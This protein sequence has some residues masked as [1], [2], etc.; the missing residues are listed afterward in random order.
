MYNGKPIIGL[1]AS[2]K[3]D[4]WTPRHFLNDSYCHAIRHFGGIPVLIPVRAQK[5][6][7]EYLMST[8]D[9]L[10]LTGGV[11]LDPSLF[12]ETVLNSTVELC[13]ERDEAEYAALRLAV[14]RDLPI[15]GICRGMQVMNVFFGGSLYQDIPAQLPDCIRHRME[16]P[17]HRTCHSCIPEPGTPLSTWGAFGVNS[18]HHQSVKEVAPGFECMGKSED[19]IVEAIFDPTHNFRWGI[20]WHPERIWDIEE[21]SSEIFRAFIKSCV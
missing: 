11:D 9:G 1:T 19:G 20:Q 10:V 17:F 6:E 21:S 5:D 14:K 18:H 3:P 8:L 16:A 2:F 4:D 13:L 15:L 12:G 7:L